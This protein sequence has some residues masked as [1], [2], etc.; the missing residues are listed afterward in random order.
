M[1]LWSQHSNISKGTNMK[2]NITIKIALLMRMGLSLLRKRISIWFHFSN[3]NSHHIGDCF[4]QH[5]T[6]RT[7]LKQFTFRNK[8]S[9]TVCRLFSEDILFLLPPAF[10]SRSSE[11]QHSF[12]LCSLLR[13]VIPSDVTFFQS[14]CT[15]IIKNPKLSQ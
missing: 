9:C 5:N 11:H 7:A 12:V 3:V 14:S 2:L 4:M 15:F 10:E 8:I 13:I 1:I 6:N